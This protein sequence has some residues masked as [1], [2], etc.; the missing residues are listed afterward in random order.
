MRHS[1]QYDF[2]SH[3]RSGSRSGD[4]LS[5]LSGLFLIVHLVLVVSDQ[6]YL[7]N[8]LKRWWGGSAISWTICRSSAPRS[9]QITTPALYY[10]N[11]LQASCSSWYQASHVK[12]LKAYVGYIKL[13]LLA[14]QLVFYVK[15]LFFLT[16]VH[17]SVFEC[18]LAQDYLFRK[19]MSRVSS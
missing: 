7:L 5:P 4:D 15:R 17:I 9:R 18:K 6:L 16:I 10:S 11:F 12:A 2:Q 3:P 8:I 1:R 19:C 13:Q 14:C